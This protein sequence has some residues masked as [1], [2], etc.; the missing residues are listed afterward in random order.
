MTKVLKFPKKVSSF[1]LVA[2]GRFTSLFL[3]T[4]NG[5]EFSLTSSDAALSFAFG[6]VNMEFRERLN[7]LLDEDAPL[8][9]F[10]LPFHNNRMLE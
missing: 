5:T 9:S 2:G 1:A 8:L 10:F 4:L 3:L 7:F 6:I